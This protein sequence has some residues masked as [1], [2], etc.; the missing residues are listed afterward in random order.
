MAVPSQNEPLPESGWVENRSRDSDWTCEPVGR[1][2][3][4]FHRALPGYVPTNLVDLPDLAREFGV[5]RVFAKDES[6]RFG[7]PAFKS[8]GAS[9]AIHRAL[10][11][12]P[13]DSNSPATIVTATD[14]N[15]GRAVA[16]FARQFGHQ[17][18]VFVPEWVSPTS[19]QAIRDEGANVGLVSGSHDDAVAVA[20]RHAEGGGE[21][22]LVQDTAWDGYEDIPGWVVEGY[23]TMFH[24]IDG[25]LSA[26]GVSQAGLVV[27]PTGVGSLAQAAVTHYRSDRSRSGARVV[28]VEPT[29]A[30]CVLR[31]VEAREPVTVETGQTVMSGLNCG[32]VST[33]AW[34]CIEHGLDGA[35]SVSDE[36]TIAA[37]QHLVSLGL[38]AGPC[39]AASLAALRVGAPHLDLPREACVI[40][41]ITEGSEA[42]PWPDGTGALGV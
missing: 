28:S 34:P 17:A 36:E 22:L 27:V 12:Q 26:A 35:I 18:D 29:T 8:L 9:W 2:V 24:E 38:D 30:A 5:A 19:V 41:L 6:T 16:R 20:V 21:R 13:A 14:G 42:N 3:L 39:G 1:E 37:G 33:L 23:S 10:K 40:L 4:D 11:D 25:Q 31:S 15:H 32:T 7:L